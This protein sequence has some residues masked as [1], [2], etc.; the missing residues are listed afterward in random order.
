MVRKKTVIDYILVEK[1]ASLGCPDFEVAYAIG[2]AP[3]TFARIK[4]RDQKL[5]ECL[6]RGANAIKVSIRRAQLRLAVPKDP[7]E[8]GNPTMLIWL[9]KQY[10]HQSDYNT[11]S[12]QKFEFEKSEVLKIKEELE[13][14]KEKLNSK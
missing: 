1:L 12:I 6:E 7:N 5:R 13:E 8:P 14:L 10:L 4:K 9:G 11:L 3:E 2:C